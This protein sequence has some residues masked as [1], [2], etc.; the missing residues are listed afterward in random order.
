MSFWR[1]IWGVFNADIEINWSE[2]EN[3]CPRNNKGQVMLKMLAF[4]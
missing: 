2:I 1:R 4:H 3:I